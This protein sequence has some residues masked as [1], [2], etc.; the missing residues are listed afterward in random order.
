MKKRTAAVLALILALV[1]LSGCA[2]PGNDLSG[3]ISGLLSQIPDSPSGSGSSGGGSSGGGPLADRDWGERNPDGVVFSDIQ[4]VRP[5]LEKLSQ[6]VKAAESAIERGASLEEVEELLD[7]CMDGYDDF[8]TMYQLA[9]IYNC[10]DL[11]DEFYAAEYEWISSAEADVSDEFDELYYACAGSELGKQL[12]EDYFWEGF[13]E[14]YADPDDSY[15]TD[16]TVALM[17]RESELISRYR[18]IVADPTVTYQGEERNVFELLDELSGFTY[19][20]VLR[21]YYEKY[22]DELADVYIELMRVRIELA[23]A[24]GFSSAEEMEYVYYFE[25]DYTPG[26]A[27]V[28]VEDV[29]TH[30]VPIY[31]W[32]RDNGVLYSTDYSSLSPDTLYSG[33]QSITD[34]IGGDCS[35][36][37]AFMS[38]YELY[39]IE[40]NIYKADTSFEVYLPS[41]EA[42]FVFLNPG[43]STRDLTTFVHEFGHFTDAYVNLGASETIDLAEVFSQA[44][45]FLS[46]S[47]MDGVLSKR[48]VAE[49]REGAMVDALDTFIQQSALADFEHRVYQLGPNALS[50]KKLNELALQTAQDFGFCEEGFEEY[51]QYFWMDITHLFEY[52]FYVI[53]YPVSL[54]VAVQIYELELQEPGRGMDK[55]FEIL[56]R[57]YDTFM[58]TVENG[59]LRSPFERGSLASVAGVIG[60]TLGYPADSAAAA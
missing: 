10:R 26:D 51:Y 50:A 30:L 8:V 54:D 48:Q 17:Q 34:S 59:G 32:A 18:E 20:S 53:S 15:Y 40:Q 19:L 43:G 1:T 2:L 5:D 7:V 21:M 14:D 57:D 16:E 13:C 37:F 45:E 38:R 3:P 49:L 22:N 27:A 36:A 52:P 29:K 28:F 41:Y 46:L 6:D 39:D 33:L 24:M 44:L 35:D 31:L 25:R 55:Y 12:E 47:H 56:P 11:R 58:E 9:N 4:Y 23:R 60:G 42:P